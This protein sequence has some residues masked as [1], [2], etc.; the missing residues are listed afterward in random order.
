MSTILALLCLA[1]PLFLAI[2]TMADDV[3]RQNS[4]SPDYR[5]GLP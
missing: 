4:K 2:G 1:F 5:D 3:R